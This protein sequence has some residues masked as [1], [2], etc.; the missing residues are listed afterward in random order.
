MAT[1]VFSAV[2]GALGASIGGT[3]FGIG[4]AAIGRAVGATLGRVLDQSILGTGAAPVEVGRIDRFRLT[5]AGE[6]APV[7][8]VFGRMRVAGHVIWASNFVEHMDESGGGKGGPPR[9]STET[10]SYTV[11]LAI[12]LCEGEIAHVGRIWADGHEIDRDT[13]DLRV[14]PGSATQDPDPAIEAIE[15][16]GAVPAYRGLAYVVIE[17]LGLGRFGNRVPQFTFEVVR[18]EQ[19]GARDLPAHV[20]GVAMLPGTG[21]YALATT[22]VQYDYGEGERVFANANSSLA[23]TD[24]EAAIRTLGAELS[25]CEAVSV[26]V[27]WFGDDLRCG[28]C[29]VRPAVE[30]RTDGLEMRWAAGGVDRASAAL[31]PSRD[32]SAV[33]GGTPADGSVIEAIRALRAA[34]QAPMF[35]PF[36]LMEQMAGN[37]LPDPYGGGEQPALPW[38]GRITLDRAPGRAGSVDGT[39]A[40]EAQVAAFFGQAAPGDFAWI[41]GR[42]VYSGPDEWSYR[43]FILHYAHLCAEA[44]GLDAFC[45]G[46]ELRGLTWIRGASG[47]PAVEA[48]RRLAAECRA[49]LGPGVKISYAADWSEYFGYAPQDGSGDLY[50]HL[51]PLWADP[52]ID[53]VGIDNYMPLSDWRDGETHADAAHGAIH[54]LGYLKSNILGGEG[55]DWFYASEA[56]RAAQIRTP[57]ED[58]AHGEPWA[59]RYKDLP[60]W[61]GRPHHER[62]GGQRRRRATDWVPGSKPVWF[63][64]LGCAAIDRGTNQ[65]N[66]FLD[67]KSSESRL[68]H[69]SRGGRDDFLQV[70]YLRA[71]SEFW[72]DPANNPAAPAYGGRMLDMTRAFVWAWDARP[73]PAFP[74]RPDLWSDA[75]NYGRG[76]WISGRSGARTLASVVVEICALAGVRDV[77]VSGLHG[78][79]RGYGITGLGDA[80]AALQPLMLTHGFDAIERGGRLV[81]RTRDG[82]PGATL[83]PARL[84][85]T[86]DLPGDLERVRAHDGAAIG[87]V[88]LSHLEA[89]ADFAVRAAEATAP[90]ARGVAV[91]QSE[92]PLVLTGA[93]GRAITA[94][95]LAEAGVARERLAFALPL[96]QIAIGAG[97]TVRLGDDRYRIDRVELSDKLTCE[98][99]RIEP[100]VYTPGADAGV[101]AVTVPARPRG[102]RPMAR[103]LDLP[104]LSGDEAPRAARL[105]VSARDWDGPRMAFGA[106]EGAGHAPLARIAAPATMGVTLTPLPAAGAGRIDRGPAL[107]VRLISGRLQSVSRARM[108]AGANVMAIG[109]GAMPGSCFSSSAPFSS[110]PTPGSCRCGCGARREPMPLSRRSGP[111]APRWF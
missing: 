27:S 1:L 32:G 12:G 76:H 75:A 87:R 74:A 21:E 14:Y 110:P 45:I 99:T 70:Q 107:S 4:S 58:G 29:R 59:W 54:D 97:D 37:G 22:P 67:P 19:S 42:M 91:S 109:Q 108:L 52:A 106:V 77:D 24:A 36:V 34:G 81:F 15:G 95:W 16:A 50:Y 10:Y 102:G 94:R 96:S 46:S 100:Q 62:I 82:R 71:L 88:R 8:Q 111:R 6:G 30:H 13:L 28:A 55:Y 103:L 56:D 80:R 63:T 78:V 60:N 101:D 73:Y 48:L 5:G 51:D 39:A 83:D 25:R 7:A 41:D 2:G 43:R 44:G 11:S 23:A 49:I 98:A 72:A 17:A 68:P 9:P 84:A 90:G 38:R 85:V 18:P 79:V 33:Y 66:K 57:I 35:Y 53:F 105:A 65:P 64:E 3:V 40:A 69:H 89:D 31:V 86:P 92:I 20:R 61:W 47:F 93:E 26:V 104:L